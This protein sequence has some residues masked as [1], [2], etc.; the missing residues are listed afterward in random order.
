MSDSKTVISVTERATKAVTAAATNLSKVV[1]DL[2]TL[3]EGSE[4]IS[5]EIQFKQQELGQIEVQFNEK[6]AEEKSKLKIKVLENEEGVL[7]NLLKSRGL[8]AIEP[9]V[10]EELR[11]ELA[12]A[13]DNN[14]D[15]INAAVADVK[16][17]AAIELNAVK[18]NL[19]SAH[20]VEMAELTANSKAKDDRI[21]MLTEQLEAA[22]ADLKAERETRLAIAQADAGRQG[23]V[24]NTG[25]N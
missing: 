2:Q 12:V 14:E 15:A 1:A 8:V 10:V 18:S 22:R 20:K 17:S 9:S 19:E 24:V 5:Q 11:N 16:R 4:K 13:Q 21:A 23:V 6:L 7:A 25:K 3:A